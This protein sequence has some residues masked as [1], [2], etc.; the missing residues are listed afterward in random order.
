MTELPEAHSTTV[1]PPV[2]TVKTVSIHWQMS[3]REKD[4]VSVGKDKMVHSWNFCPNARE[5]C[6]GAVFLQRGCNT[7][8]LLPLVFNDS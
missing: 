4:K 8:S 3:S 6:G 7:V 5:H 1:Q 2:V